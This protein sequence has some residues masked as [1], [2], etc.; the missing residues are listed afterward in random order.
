MFTLNQSNIDKLGVALSKQTDATDREWS[1]IMQT[2]KDQMAAGKTQID[3]IIIGS[4]G[5]MITVNFQ[6][7]DPLVISLTRS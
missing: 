4:P 6:Q 7:D 1:A 5:S 3:S 2:A